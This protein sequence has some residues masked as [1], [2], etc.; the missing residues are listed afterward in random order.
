MPR[1][2]WPG[3]AWLYGAPY[4]ALVVVPASSPVAVAT[5]SFGAADAQSR[6]VIAR[7]SGEEKTAARTTVSRV[8]ATRATTNSLTRS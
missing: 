2:V 4:V 1:S 5:T 7:S 6:M 8:I 3:A